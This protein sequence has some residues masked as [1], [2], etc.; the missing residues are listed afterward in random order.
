MKLSDDFGCLE[1]ILK[2]L[3]HLLH[4][5]VLCWSTIEACMSTSTLTSSTATT[6]DGDRLGL[7]DAPGHVCVSS[8]QLLTNFSDHMASVFFWSAWRESLIVGFVSTAETP[9]ESSEERM[10]RRG[11]ATLSAI[12][13]FRSHF[14]SHVPPSTLPTEILESLWGSIFRYS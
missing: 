4:F 5:K 6:S 7:L 3:R 12:L 10:W 13:L 1:W 14:E 11:R 8:S 2:R 9:K